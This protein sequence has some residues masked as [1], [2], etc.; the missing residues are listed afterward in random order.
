[1]FVISKKHKIR[2]LQIIIIIRKNFT[3]YHPKESFHFCNYT[4]KF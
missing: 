3:T 4:L 2:V 1:M